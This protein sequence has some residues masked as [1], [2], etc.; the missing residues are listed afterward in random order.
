LRSCLTCGAEV[1]RKPKPGR[2]ALY[3][4]SRC[5]HI[6]RRGKNRVEHAKGKRGRRVPSHPLAGPSEYVAVSRLV[7][8]EKIGPGP[9]KCHWC[10]C[11]IRWLPGAR[12]AQGALIADHLNWNQLDDRPENLVPSCNI[13]NAHRTRSGDRRRVKDDEPFLIVN[14]AKGP[15]RTRA[16][17]RI[18]EAC[19]VEFLALPAHVRKGNARFCSFVCGRQ[20]SRLRRGKSQGE[21]SG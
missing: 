6:S 17:T 8:Y 3:C 20:S 7:L 10:G 9:H 14:T 2:P 12:V 4:S 15:V 19:G 11:E 21:D 16:V 5:Y 13:C 1:L 18:C